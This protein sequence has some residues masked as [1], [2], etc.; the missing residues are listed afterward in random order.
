MAYQKNTKSYMCATVSDK[1]KC[2]Q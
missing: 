1:Q 2:L